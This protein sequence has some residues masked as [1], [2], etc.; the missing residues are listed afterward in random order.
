MNTRAIEYD[1]LKETCLQQLKAYL[2]HRANLGVP[3]HAPEDS[4]YDLVIPLRG[5][6][7]EHLLVEIKPVER[8][9]RAQ[10][11]HLIA[12]TAHWTPEKGQHLTLW[13]PWIPEEMGALLRE[14]KI[15]YTD[16]LGNAYLDLPRRGV[17]I[18][19]RGRKPERNQR[20]DRGRLLEPT[21]LKVLHHLLVNSKAANAPYRDLALQAGV[22]LGTVA[23]VMKELRSG[24][25]L[26]KT[27][28]NAYKLMKRPELIDLFVRGYALK[29][30]PECFIGKYRHEITNP[31]HLHDH[32]MN[33]LKP[34]NIEV[35]ATGTRAAEHWTGYLH[36]DTVTLFVGDEA[37]AILTKEHMLP[38]MSGG[39]LTLLKFF[40][41]TVQDARDPGRHYAT[42]LLTY[43]ELLY[44]GRA[45]EVE[46]AGMVFDRYLK[47]NGRES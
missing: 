44:D 22:A 18:D 35:A 19:V 42:P 23:F 5:I 40:G 43:A 39:N 27:G 46:T 47:E 7:L 12:R 3:K 25:Y 8:I 11:N 24:A 33:E 10:I 17:L 14:A 9:A 20:A 15:F 37:R 4:G 6:P 34:R 31:Q 1:R 30:R 38:D 41:P 21:G 32:L 36:A 29:L 26:V 13:A 28:K 2:T 45:R 16:A